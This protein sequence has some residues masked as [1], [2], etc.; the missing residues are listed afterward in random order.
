[1]S[2]DNQPVKFEWTDELVKEFADNVPVDEMSNDTHIQH[3]KA[4]KQPKQERIEISDIFE[5]NTNIGRKTYSGY[6]FTST[7]IISTDK[8]PSIK[9]AIESVLNNDTE[10]KVPKWYTKQEIYEWLRSKNYSKEIAFELAGYWYNDLQGAFK[11]GWEKAKSECKSEPTLSDYLSSLNSKD[12]G[13][14][15]MS[16]NQIGEMIEGFYKEEQPTNDNA[17][18]D[19]H[20]WEQEL[21]KCKINPYYYYTKYMTANGKPCTTRLSE[22]EFNDYFFKVIPDYPQSK[23]SA[24]EPSAL[25]TK[26]YEI[27]SFSGKIANY[28]FTSS[29]RTEEWVNKQIEEGYPIH[30][31][32]RLSDNVVFSVGDKIYD[33]W[34]GEHSHFSGTVM[35]FEINTTIMLI[36]YGEGYKTMHIANAKKLPPET[37]PIVKDKEALFTTEDG[38]K[39]YD[40]SKSLFAIIKKDKSFYIHENFIGANPSEHYYFSTKEAAEQYIIENKPCLSVLELFSCYD[41]THYKQPILRDSS[42]YI[43][44]IEKVKQKLKQ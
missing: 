29:P 35:G 26:E 44:L 11:K 43:K 37:P 42:L 14:K 1:M 15:K 19:E 5:A 9:Q 36:K 20:F 13:K 4:S 24:P 17:F 33:G 8:F 25:P 31:V 27:L 21:H 23:Q 22:Q 38:V 32:R 3:F 40:Y 39:I 12:T 18:V 2:T 10:D 34:E 30:S 6:A 7:S 16:K 28:G 41:G